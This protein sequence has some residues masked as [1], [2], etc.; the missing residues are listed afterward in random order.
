ML[1]PAGLLLI[2]LQCAAGYDHSYTKQ[3][4]FGCGGYSR[5]CRVRLTIGEGGTYKSSTGSTVEQC[6]T[7]C[8]KAGSDCG[9][10]EYD[11]TTTR[12]SFRTNTLCNRAPKVTKDCYTKAYESPT[13][14]EKKASRTPTA[15]MAETGPKGHGADGHVNQPCH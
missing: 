3:S 10:F 4:G 11:S 14:A 12:C 15:T 6:S 1:L 7:T 5:D 9:G 13:F 2:I 8:S